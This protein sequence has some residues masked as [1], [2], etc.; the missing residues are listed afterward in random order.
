MPVQVDP[1]FV[2]Q[3]APADVSSAVAKELVPKETKE[4]LPT[5]QSKTATPAHTSKKF[6]IFSLEH[7]PQKAKKQ[8]RY[9][10]KQFLMHRS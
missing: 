3:Q 10:V 2:V 4:P 8:L 7:A 5:I 6:S 1:V 9:V